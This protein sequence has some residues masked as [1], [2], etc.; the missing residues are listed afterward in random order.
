[1]PHA[2]W[3]LP[4]ENAPYQNGRKRD[5][6][7][8]TPDGRWFVKRMGEA[9]R[10]ASYVV[11]LNGERVGPLHEGVHVAR[12]WVEAEVARRGATQRLPS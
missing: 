11:K 9:S 3:K 5:Y 7:V 1:M 2:K 12:K 4:W 10:N 6:Y 8:D